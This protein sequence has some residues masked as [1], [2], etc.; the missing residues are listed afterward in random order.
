MTAEKAP[1]RE[2]LGSIPRLYKTLNSSLQ[3]I[4]LVTIHPSAD[5]NSEII[6]HLTHTTLTSGTKYEA[7][8]YVWGVPSF[9]QPISLDGT[10][11]NVTTNL[12]EALRYLRLPTEERILWI[13]AICINQSDIDERGEQVGYMGE[14]YRGCTVDLLWLEEEEQD[15]RFEKAVQI[16]EFFAKGDLPA[17]GWESSVWRDRV[18]R[19]GEEGRDQRVWS[20]DLDDVNHNIS[21][22]KF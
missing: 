4:R 14:I 19:E 20:M 1:P 21:L 13:D 5:F 17:L 2:S 12:E 22:P 18:V 7:L 9:T 6:C 10:T 3:E 15:S 11:F 16:M 8:S